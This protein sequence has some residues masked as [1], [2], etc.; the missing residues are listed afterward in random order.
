MTPGHKG[1]ARRK[2]RPGNASRR[3]SIPSSARWAD[4]WAT[5]RSPLQGRRSGGCSQK[6][7]PPNPWKHG[8]L[9][10][11]SMT[12]LYPG[13]GTLNISPWSPLLGAKWG[14]D[15]SGAHPQ[16]FVRVCQSPRAPTEVLQQSKAEGRV[17]TRSE[18]APFFF[19]DS[20]LICQN[21]KSCSQ[22]ERA[23]AL[24]NCK[25]W[26]RPFAGSRGWS[27]QLLALLYF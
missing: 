24:W 1:D 2:H 11:L 25:E 17:F 8:R 16:F 23:T 7:R 10:I 3:S 27:L 12:P 5:S 13:R 19:T 15:F 14:R 6:D 18:S 4:L 26:K 21:R 20:H 22:S 9:M